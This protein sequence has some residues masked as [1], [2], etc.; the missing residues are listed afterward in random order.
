MT[1]ICKCPTCGTEHVV[2][3]GTI[4]QPM[5][6]VDKKDIPK[7]PNALSAEYQVA[8]AKSQGYDLSKCLEDV[9][10]K[11]VKHPPS[12]EWGI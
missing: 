3:P 8:K 2:H 10:N 12:K 6:V 4:I 5:M 7:L 9:G 11:D 1:E